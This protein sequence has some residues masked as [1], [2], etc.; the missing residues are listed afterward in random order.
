[1]TTEPTAKDR[2]TL[3]RKIAAVTAAV[4]RIPKNGENTFHRYKY[5]TES[6]ITDGLRDLLKENGLAFLPPSV[7]S[8]ERDEM[9]E[10]G[11]LGPRTRVQVQFGLACC[12]TGEVFTA[13]FW[14]EGQDTADKGFYKAYTGAVK[15]FLLKTFLIATG[16]DP[17]HQDQQP[18]QRQAQQQRPG[19]SY[20][21][22]PERPAPAANGNGNTKRPL[23]QQELVAALKTLWVEERRL[24]GETPAAEIATDLEEA[25]REQL[26]ELGKKARARVLTLEQQR[27]G[28]P[29]VDL[30]SS[31]PATTA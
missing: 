17:E 12:E 31:P 18:Q 22:P 19:A 14:G 2:A 11:K 5:A 29:E 23:T 16:D 25:S 13:A 10:N 30:P 1:M 21:P 28:M 7:I 4:S 8:W 15:Y 20:T 9:V 24:G 27:Q 26:I 6:D 3:Y